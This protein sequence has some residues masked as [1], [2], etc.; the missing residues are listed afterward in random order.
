MHYV[1]DNCDMGGPC[2]NL[3]RAHNVVGLLITVNDWK[4]HVAKWLV[5]TRLCE[6]CRLV[7][8]HGPADLVRSGQFMLSC[9]P[10]ETAAVWRPLWS[11]HP[12]FVPPPQGIF[13]YRTPLGKNTRRISLCSHSVRACYE[14]FRDFQCTLS[15][16]KRGSLYFN[17]NLVNHNR[18]LRRC[19]E[20]QR[21]L[22]TRK[23]SVGPSICLSVRRVDCEK[24]EYSSAQIFVPYE[25]SFIL[26][27][28]WWGRL[29][30]PKIFGQTDPVISKTEILNRYSLVAPQP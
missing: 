7:D 13:I 25:R 1:L 5:G 28:G 8:S 9:R 30:L 10:I 19:I 23:L 12:Q 15:D 22:A 16:V 2:V 21:K 29:L 26:L 3:G 14:R 6:C 17:V 4:R 24:I 18:F 11:G 20:C 27:F